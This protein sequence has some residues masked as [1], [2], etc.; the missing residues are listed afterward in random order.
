MMLVLALVVVL[1]VATLAAEKAF[2]MEIFSEDIEKVIE[3]VNLVIAAFA[4][5]F[6]I[7]LAALA[8]GG[9]QEKTWNTLAFAAVLFLLLEVVGALNGFGLVH[10]GGLAE[11]FEFLFV[12]T[13]AYTL[14]FTKRDLLASTMG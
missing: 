14:Y 1:P 12:S 11:V 4:G 3:L 6:A 5:I 13:L 9:K 10:I 8:Q 7:K 2:D